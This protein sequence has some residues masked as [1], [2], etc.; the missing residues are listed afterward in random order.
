MGFGDSSFQSQGMTS[1]GGMGGGRGPAGRRPTTAGVSKR[2]TSAAEKYARFERTSFSGY[3]PMSPNVWGPP[4]WDFLFSVCFSVSGKEEREDE[5]IRGFDLMRYLLPCR[6][7]QASFSRTYKA[8]PPSTF[9][10]G[11]LTKWLWMVHDE[12]NK[13]LGKICISYEALKKRHSSFTFLS[14][15]VTFLEI[16]GMMFHSSP[17]KHHHK[18]LS[19]LY[20]FLPSL[21]DSGLNLSLPA[22][23]S[24]RKEEADTL[25]LSLQMGEETSRGD[26]PPSSSLSSPSL[27]LFLEEVYSSLLSSLGI[28]KE[29]DDSTLEKKAHRAASEVKA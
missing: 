26:E 14:S 22:I 29:G 15:E 4:L 13:K 7:C 19:F 9:K 2:R 5:L 23:L 20:T 18:V 25:L 21:Q 24:K 28:E 8:Y 11:K 1:F 16:V 12:V 17:K 6:K 3:V 27:S 10:G